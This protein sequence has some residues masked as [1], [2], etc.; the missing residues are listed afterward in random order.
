MD[1]L[2]RHLVHLHRPTINQYVLQ[3]EEGRG[4]DLVK[5]GANEMF[6]FV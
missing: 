3:N 5:V 1:H 6:F 4:T 2:H